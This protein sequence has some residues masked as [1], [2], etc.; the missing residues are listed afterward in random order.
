MSTHLPEA[1]L[2]GYLKQ[3][4]A[5]SP[6]TQTMEGQGAGLGLSEFAPAPAI[7]TAAPPSIA[8]VRRAYE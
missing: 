7:A 1:A 4:A 5:S 3:L 6:T 2:A 8:T